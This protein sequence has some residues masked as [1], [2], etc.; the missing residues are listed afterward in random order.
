VNRTIRAVVLSLLFFVWPGVFVAAA[1]SVSPAAGP[2]TVPLT[3]LHTNDTHGHLLPFSYPTV[4]AAGSDL[5]MPK[6]RTDIGGIAR[7]A[8]LVRQ[9]R[10]QLAAR[11]TTVW[12]VDA[13]DFS[14]GTPTST[15]YL[16]EADV[17]AM[18]AAGYDMATIG[19]HEF[20]NPLA[21]MKKLVGLARFPILC[22]NAADAATGK[23]L[24]QE[25]LVRNIGPLRIGVFGLITRETATY[26]GAKEGVKIADEIE[27]ARRL[28]GV[29]RPK[30]DIVIAISHAGERLDNVIAGQ[31][32]GIDVIVGGHS[33][34]RLPTGEF[35]W[36]SEDLKVDDVNGTVIVQ[37]HQWAGELGRLDLLFEK[38]ERGAWHVGR[39]RARLIPITSA[40]P[41]DTKVA[42]IVDEYWRPI[43]SRYGEVIGQAEGDFSSRCDDDAAYNLVADAVRETFG[44][45]ID[46]E[47]AGGVRAPLVKG[48]ITRGDMVSLD[49]FINTVVLFKVSGRDLKRILVQHRPA[50]SGVRYRTENREL[51]EA[52]VNGRP[53]EDDRVY[54]AATN[55][56]FAG[57][58]LKGIDTQDT[59]RLRLDV[60]IDYVK[61]KG[62]LKPVYDGR[63]V[64]I[65]G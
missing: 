24:G 9:V 53:I 11:N 17:A 51:V 21:Q 37:A 59:T 39:Y 46:L 34:S 42:A 8:T 44:T 48:Q 2:A 3:I 25:Y 56:Y 55:S 14:D 65:G 26:P 35:V 18:N 43:A 22:A 30:A 52:A 38:D 5:A 31:V 47:N 58:A 16:G 62:T 60:V 23:P 54:T 28:V 15:E 27:T 40:I 61:K 10:E 50:V 49:P 64:V 41:A 20:N 36:R 19:N 45:E 32:P 7:R 63:R 12:L 57:V 33:H 1:Q 4:L 13:G 6:E 29:L